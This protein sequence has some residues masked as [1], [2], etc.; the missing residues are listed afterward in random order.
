MQEKDYL[1]EQLQ[2]NRRQIED[3]SRKVDR[4]EE[5]LIKM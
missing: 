2:S 3:K 5:D 4:F 1:A